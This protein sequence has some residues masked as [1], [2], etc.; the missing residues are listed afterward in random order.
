MVSLPSLLTA[1]PSND[2][3]S[4]K[5]VSVIL[6]IPFFS[7]CIAPPPS[8]ELFDKNV[9]SSITNSPVLLIA[10]PYSIKPSS[11]AMFSCS[12]HSFMDIVPSFVIAPP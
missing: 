3:L 4:A 1:P 8:T 7:L 5:S 10:P 11:W 12:S 9:D 6:T 2:V